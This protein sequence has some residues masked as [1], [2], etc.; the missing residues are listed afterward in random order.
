MEMFIDGLLAALIRSGW[1]PDDVAP[2][3][4]EGQCTW[5][6]NLLTSVCHGWQQQPSVSP[7]HKEWQD[8]LEK[9]IAGG[10]RLAFCRSSDADG[11]G[12][13]LMWWPCALLEPRRVAILS[14]RLG[15]ALERREPVIDALRTLCV[16][17]APRQ[18]SLVTCESTATDRLV[19]HCGQLFGLTVVSIQPPKVRMDLAHW[20]KRLK[21]L[22]RQASVQAGQL[23]VFL[24]PPLPRAPNEREVQ[25]PQLDQVV[26]HQADDLFVLHLRPDGNLHR[27]LPSLLSRRRERPR[28]VFL[29]IGN[30]LVPGQLADGLLRA[31]AVGWHRSGSRTRA[32]NATYG[33][34]ARHTFDDAAARVV[35]WSECDPWVYLMHWTRSQS[36][37]WPGQT[38][39]EY[40]NGLLFAECRT[41]RSPLSSLARILAMQRIIAT[42]RLTRGEPVVCFTERRLGELARYRRYRP[43]L[44][45]WDF[46]PYGICIDRKWLCQRQTRPVI[47]G[48]D[49]RWAR[50]SSDEQPFFQPRLL[51]QY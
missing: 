19:R 18:H 11:P 47:Y 48:D 23:P 10:A 42:N 1:L 43:H 17:L 27:L 9:S 41:D 29:A 8:W 39:E 26:A 28:L 24:S 35:S 31:G 32:A 6:G 33:A 3:Q 46:E 13:R 5:S 37:P 44:A 30:G 2:G 25:L 12:W 50:L 49:R 38:E 34:S 16:N 40:L 7:V 20:L 36:G 22:P 21:R 45:R 15:R 4:L 51:L 14:S